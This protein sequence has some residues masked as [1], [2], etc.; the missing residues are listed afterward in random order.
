MKSIKTL[1]K[2]SKQK[3]DE[4]RREL[5]E[6]ETQKEQ[7]LEY[8]KLMAEE[9]VVERE[10][11]ARE[12]WASITFDSYKKKIFE[13]QTNI[14]MVIKDLERQA[15]IITDEI[16]ELFGEVKKYEIILEQKILAEENERKSR[17]DKV[18]D[19]VGLVGYLKK[20]E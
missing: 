10:F 17:E 4:K 8:S 16:R 12:P 20:V 3:L 1:I 9:L 18:L 6:L 7:M 2:I 19:E 11:A 5:F 14:A 15:V 13:K